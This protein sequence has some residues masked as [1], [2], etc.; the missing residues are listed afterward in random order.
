MYSYPG[1]SLAYRRTAEELG[2]RI[3]A[4]IPDHPEILTLGS[5]WDLFKVPGFRCDDLGPSLAQASAAL[6]WARDRW[7]S[8]H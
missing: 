6:A 7:R 3:L 5:H 4:L 8:E 1:L 2:E